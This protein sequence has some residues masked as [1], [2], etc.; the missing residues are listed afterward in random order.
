MVNHI[1]ITVIFSVFVIGC[2]H[3]EKGMNKKRFQSQIVG[4]W[5]SLTIEKNATSFGFRELELTDKRWSLQL[6]IFGDST[7]NSPLFRLELTGPYEITAPSA[8]MM[9][10]FDGTYFIEKQYLT[11]FTENNAILASLGFKECGISKGTRT[12]VSS[13]CSFIKPIA[14]CPADYDLVTIRDGLL[15][16]GKRTENMCVPSGRPIEHGYPLKRRS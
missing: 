3:P 16:A 13:G 5:E 12:D 10:S 8:K 15:Y 11:V 9:G 7:G 6:T 2:Q 1:L 4:E 14:K